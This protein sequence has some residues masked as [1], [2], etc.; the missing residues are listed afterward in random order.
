MTTPDPEQMAGKSLFV[1]PCPVVR[2]I[3][4]CVA[5]A[6]WGKPLAD[7]CSAAQRRQAR[8]IANNIKNALTKASLLRQDE[9]PEYF[10][11]KDRA[12]CIQ[13][14]QDF[15]NDPVE[16]IVGEALDAAGYAPKHESH[17][18]RAGDGPTLDFKLAD[19]IYV[20]VKRMHT[21]RVERQLA[22]ASDVILIQG[23]EA[24][25][26]FAQAIEGPTQ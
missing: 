24:A 16:R 3:A 21:P 10:R 5:Q 14:V 6:L 25:R 2:A 19:G 9:R 23:I 13:L 11:E 7:N 4:P 18:D 1:E 20:E 15:T 17:P 8:N 22:Q 12:D 26:W